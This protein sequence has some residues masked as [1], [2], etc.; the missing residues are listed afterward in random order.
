MAFKEKAPGEVQREIAAESLKQLAKTH[1]IILTPEISKMIIDAAMSAK[2]NDPIE[3]KVQTE[4]YKNLVP[5]KKAEQYPSTTVSDTYAKG[6][7][8]PKG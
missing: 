1:R 8:K 5:N 7:M 6:H 4:F 3:K 2:G